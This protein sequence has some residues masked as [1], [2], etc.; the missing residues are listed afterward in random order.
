MNSDRLMTMLQALE[1]CIMSVDDEE[2]HE[3][4]QIIDAAFDFLSQEIL[5]EKFSTASLGKTFGILCTILAEFP[6]YRL[7][8]AVEP[9]TKMPAKRSLLD[10]FKKRRGQAANLLL[11]L[12]SQSQLSFLK[13]NM[14]V[15]QRLILSTLEPRRFMPFRVIQVGKIADQLFEYSLYFDI[16]QASILRQMYLF[17]YARFGTSGWRARWNIDCNEYIVKC[18]AQAICDFVNGKRVPEFVGNAVPAAAGRAGKA[19]LIGYDSRVN[20]RR[21]AE[22]VAHVATEN[23]IQV[24]ITTRDTPTPALIYWATEVIGESGIA[25]IVNCTASHNPPEWQG[26]KF[27]P[28]NGVPAPTAVTDFL[29]AR[30]NQLKLRGIRFLKTP[31]GYSQHFPESQRVDPQESYCTWLLSPQR[32]GIPINPVALRRH[33]AE[34]MIIIDEMHGASR[35]YFRRLMRQLGVRYSVIHG[36]RSQKALEELGYASPEWPYIAPLAEEVIRRKATLGVGFDTDGDRFGIISENGKYIMPNQILPLLIDYLLEQGFEGKIIRT[37]SGSRLINRIAESRPIPAKYRPSANVVPSYLNHAFYLTVKGSEELFRG[38]SVFLEPVGIKYVIEGMLLDPEYRISYGP[39]FRDTMLLGGE[40]SS[41]LTSKG[42]I[43]DKDGIWGNL[44]V[45][46][47]LA[48]KAASIDTLWKNLCSKYGVAWFERLDIDAGDLA[49]EQL[50]K[51]FFDSSGLNTFAGMDIRFIGGVMYD[52]VEVQL[53][54]KAPEAEVY[55]E[56]RASG[57]EPLNRIYVEAIA[58]PTTTDTETESLVREVQ[59]EVLNLLEELSVNEINSS[60]SP[61]ELASILAVTSPDKTGVR[62]VVARLFSSISLRRDT[63]KRLKQKLPYL[64]IRNRATARKWLSIFSKDGK[65]NN[66][67]EE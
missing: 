20:A 7:E 1:V 55:L 29:A 25:G 42:H 43:P 3:A 32:N 22:W 38:L 15:L 51:Y 17:K 26:I 23:G 9:G 46:N 19:L 6:P 27:S 52:M 16:Y 2:I 8:T 56:V 62:K 44:L 4:L 21:I 40:E 61:E 5:N 28:F 13:N 31:R 39:N 53:H 10:A 45:M 24:T 50:V 18:V 34:K 14:H 30:A 63:L 36:Q 33:F 47:M 66:N 37:V 59:Q 67:E 48:V 41:G 35:G 65:L 12:F 49:K 64:E 57:T 11:D 58:L 54:S 60:R